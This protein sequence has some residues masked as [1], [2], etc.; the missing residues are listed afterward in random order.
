MM[1]KIKVKLR[2]SRIAGKAGSI[3]YSV[4]HKRIVRH[5]TTNMRLLPESWDAEGQRLVSDLPD[6][7]GTQNRI[8]SDLAALRQIVRVL[9][10]SGKEFSA[11][12]IVARFR[13]PERHVSVVAF[14]QEQIRILTEC[15]RL[16]TA[17]NY[18]RSVS[19]LSAF[20]AGR[21][22]CFSQLTARFVEDYKD[23]LLRKGLVRNSLSFHMRILRAVYNKAV[24]RGYAEQTLPFRDVYTGID[25]TRK[26]AVGEQV[27]A[28]LIRLD[29]K[30]E[31][32]LSFTR[33]LFLFSFYTRGMAFVDMAYLRKSDIRDGNIVYARHKTGQRLAV[34]IEPCIRA[35]IDR[36]DEEGTPYIFPILR[37]DDPAD[38]FRRYKSEL[39]TYNT[40][41]VQLSVRMGLGQRI[42]SYTSRH[43]WANIARKRNIPLPVISAGMGHS[44]ERTTRI[45]L[46]SL[47]NSLIDDANRSIIDSFKNPF[48]C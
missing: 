3:Y 47:E 46:A 42:S 18:R 25:Q 23:F 37:S 17:M 35:I 1:A 29:L 14:F 48:S 33:D 19:A 43:T 31:A 13:A 2:P 40:R 20:L 39:R 36:Y 6:A 26:R 5:I 9:E 32:S 7:G 24:R 27:I 22:L 15:N 45:Y 44:S 38:C 30:D 28:R 16:G 11:D 4:S 8:D 41:L 21:D 10:C 12:E 34:R